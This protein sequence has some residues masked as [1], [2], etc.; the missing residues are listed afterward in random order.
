LINGKEPILLEHD[1]L[2]LR[3]LEDDRFKGERSVF[4]T[5]DRRLHEDLSPSKFRHLRDSMISH[6]GLLQMIDLLVGLD[7]DKRQVG[8]LLW[9]NTV[10][11]RTQKI[12]SYLVAEA[13]N[14][15]D[16]ARA[17]GMHQIVEAHADRI[18][19]ELERRQLDLDAH[20]PRQRTEAFRTLGALDDGFFAG[21]KEAMEKIESR[22][23]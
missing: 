11:N 16:A 13:L 8:Q 6:V 22:Y 3:L 19:R 18:S 23:K 21:M 15:Y 10:S 7:V 9:S 12:R 2:Q 5:A 14:E 1:A 4:V 20:D 17:M